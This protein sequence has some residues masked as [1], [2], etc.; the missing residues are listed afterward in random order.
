MAH[1]WGAR[2]LENLQP[3]DGHLDLFPRAF[4]KHLF[5]PSAY[6]QEFPVITGVSRFQK[7]RWARL[8]GQG[9]STEFDGII[10]SAI[11]V[12]AQEALILRSIAAEGEM[13]HATIANALEYLSVNLLCG[14]IGD[15]IPERTLKD[16]G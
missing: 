9:M 1:Q 6:A 13:D 4:Y 16:V 14:D 2:A 11:Y 15:E 8:F 10:F 7:Y 5:A 12:H 3:L